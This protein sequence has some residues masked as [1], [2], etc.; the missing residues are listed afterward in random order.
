M[1]AK[2]ATQILADLI[3]SKRAMAEPDVIIAITLGIE[4]LKRHVAK[5]TLTFSGIS[6]PLPGET[7][8]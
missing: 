6:Q 4:A 1:T 5:S 3:L 2:Q 7:P 8:G